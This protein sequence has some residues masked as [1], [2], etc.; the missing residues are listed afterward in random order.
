MEVKVKLDRQVFK[1]EQASIENTES[2]RESLETFVFLD[3]CSALE[4]L[5][6]VGHRN[7]GRWRIVL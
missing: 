7:D 3:S 1:I 2:A 5:R 6:L 4:S